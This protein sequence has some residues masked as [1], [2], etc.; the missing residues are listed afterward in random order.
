MKI[1][2]IGAGWYGC[3]IA[4]SLLQAGHDVTIFEKSNSSISG[5]SKKNQNRLHLGFHYPRCH[6]TRMQSKEGFNWFIEHYEHL[7]RKINRNYYAVSSNDSLIDFDTFKIIMNGSGLD[8]KE[9]V[10]P[11]TFLNISNVIECD[12]RVIRNDL[13]SNYFNNILKDNIIFNTYVDLNNEDVIEALNNKYDYIIDCSWGTARKIEGLSYF[14]EPCIYFYYRK[15]SKEEEFAL[16]IMDGKHYSLY[17]YYDDIYTLTSVEHTPLG[18]YDHI[19]DALVKMA[20]CKNNN[21]LTREK[22][23]LFEKEFSTFYP[24]FLECFEFVS[25]EFSLKTKIHSATDFR[26]CIVQ[27]ADQII[28]VF[29]GKIDTLHIAEKAIFEAI[30]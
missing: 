7:T 23:Y 3:H 19:N 8:F 24:E 28:S 29:S 30:E 4:S 12:E 1:S 10:K 20:G 15:K 5:A 14:Y 27:K 18:Q 11:N 2:I 6:Q 22:Q 21:K 16:T 9:K 17:P 13:A 26:G 25:C